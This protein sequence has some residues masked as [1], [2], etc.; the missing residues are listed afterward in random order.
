MTTTIAIPGKK[1]DEPV[2]AT[3][4]SPLYRISHQPSTKYDNKEGWVTIFYHMDKTGEQ[5]VALRMIQ[6]EM[7]QTSIR[8]GPRYEE[9]IVL[10]MFR[11]PELYIDKDGLW[12]ADK[13]QMIRKEIIELFASHL[14]RDAQDNYHIDW[15]NQLYPV[16]V[17]DVPYFVQSLTE[18]AGQLTVHL[19]DGREFPFPSG[20]IMIR[21][22]IPYISLFGQRDTKLSRPAYSELCKNLI[23]RAGNYLIRCG[24]NEWLVEDEPQ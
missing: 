6:D 21:N 9:E 14:Q 13:V 7:A 23:E 24:E 11:A 3:V 12:Y 10:D 15:Q 2:P 19:Y 5:E 1:I 17:E 22:N 16:Q 18:Q 4:D 20:N 8:M